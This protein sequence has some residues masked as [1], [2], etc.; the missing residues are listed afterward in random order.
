M[1]VKNIAADTVVI[2]SAKEKIEKNTLWLKKVGNDIYIDE[3]VKVM[4]N[5]INQSTTA[6]NN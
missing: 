2:N 1:T 3:T 6:K 5:M 4:N